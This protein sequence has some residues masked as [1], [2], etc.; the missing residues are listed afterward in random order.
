ME[1]LDDVGKMPPSEMEQTVIFCLAADDD[2][3]EYKKEWK[4]NCIAE[5][6]KIDL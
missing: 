4:G 6:A 2:D 3:E 1:V 5:Y